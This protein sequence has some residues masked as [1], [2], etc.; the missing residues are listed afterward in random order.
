MSIW[1]KLQSSD[2]KDRVFTALNKNANYYNESILGVPASHLDDKVFYQDNPFLEHAP[3]LS[4]LIHNPNHIGF[5]TEGV[6]ESFFEGTHEIEKELIKV[7]AEDILLGEEDAQ[8]GYVAAGGTEANMQAIWIYRNLF[9]QEHNADLKEICIICSED[10][11]YSMSKASNVFQIPIR[12]VSVDSEN[13][14][15]VKNSINEVISTAQAAGVKHFI[16]VANMMTT[17]FGSVDR[18][19]DYTDVLI[20]LNTSF[21]LHV[22]GAFGGFFYPFAEEKMKLNFANPHITSV[23]LDA[24]KMLQAPYGTG[25]F[26]ILKGYMNYAMTKEASYVKGEDCTLI[27]SRSGAN[28]IAFWMILMTYGP[29]GWREKVLVLLNRTDKLCA[30]LNKI[31]VDYFRKKGSNIITIKSASI[32]AEIAEKYSLVPNTHLNPSWYKIVIMDHV[33]LEKLLPFMEEL[34]SCSEL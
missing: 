28:A 8:D 32:P 21:K 6:S 16:V 7:C 18:I 12:F 27:G 15:L 10:S 9:M 4:T 20:K 25:L 22:D 13:R 1:K 2:I 23:T 33:T 31:N 30:F 34:K 3:F 5:H 19:E 24:H 29:Y 26:L 14:S 11:H 17:M